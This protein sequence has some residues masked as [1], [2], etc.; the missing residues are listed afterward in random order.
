MDELARHVAEMLP[1]PTEEVDLVVPYSRGD[2]VS[3]AHRDGEILAESYAEG[4]TRLHALVDA[5]LAAELRSTSA[6]PA[7]HPA[8]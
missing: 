6:A 7:A 2:L 1:R 8:S 5:G 4:G 3:R